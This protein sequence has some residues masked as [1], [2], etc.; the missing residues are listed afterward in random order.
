[1]IDVVVDRERN[2]K[3]L[4]QIG[5]PQ[6]E[7]KIYVEN[8]VYSKIKEENHRDKTVYVFMG[9]TER[10]NGKYAT[11]VEGA[12]PVNDMEFFGSVPR[13]NNKIWS[14]VFREIKRIYEDMIIVGW[15]LDMKGLAPRMTKELERVHREFFGGIHQ[16]FLLMDS[17]E[18]EET[19]YTY[20]ENSLVPKEGFYI[21]YHTKQSLRLQEVPKFEMIDLNQ[22]VLDRDSEDAV[23]QMSQGG[24]ETDIVPTKGGRY[25]E[26]LQT[27]IRSEEK[28][29]SNFGIAVAVALLIFVIGVGAYENRNSLF[30]KSGVPTVEETGYVPSES[31]ESTATNVGN[32]EIHDTE[33]SNEET[34]SEV[35]GD[36]TDTQTTIP[37]EIIPGETEKS[38][39]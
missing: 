6:K 10:M 3:N 37:V 15:A 19:F 28:E 16:I 33:T 13:W 23:R 4:K 12:I 34:A 17:L 20:K 14:G 5:T 1:M 35:L 30:G 31:T 27:K 24:I 29:G 18:K 7:D 32:S 25:R 39:E 38:S 8:L 21:Y 2:L 36:G 22:V 11:F 9:H 26:L